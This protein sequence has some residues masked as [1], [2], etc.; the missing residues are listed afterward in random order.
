MERLKTNN[1]TTSVSFKKLT[2]DLNFSENLDAIEYERVFVNC[3]R[4]LTK[5]WNNVKATHKLRFSSWLR[6]LQRNNWYYT[7]K[8]M[9]R[10][11]TNNNTT[12]V[13]FKKLTEDLNFSENLD[14]I[15]YERVFV[16]CQR[17][18]TKFWSNV[19]ATHKLRFLLLFHKCYNMHICFVSCVVFLFRATGVELK[20]AWFSKASSFFHFLSR[21]L[22]CSTV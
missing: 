13:S 16:N 15:E 1:N 21:F 9:E 19:K 17:W 8:E 10:L 14:A 3:Q 2:E 18:L 12:S 20:L 6:N 5:F 11:K 4:W 7:A 22:P